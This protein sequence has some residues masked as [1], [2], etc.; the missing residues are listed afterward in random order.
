MPKLKEFRLK[1][2]LSQEDLAL[3]AGV[4]PVTVNR[5]EKGH[6]K[7]K[8]QTIRKLAEALEVE[9]GEIEF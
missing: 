4:A 8:F 1:L 2:F 6:H 3:K 7:P 5:L 9:P